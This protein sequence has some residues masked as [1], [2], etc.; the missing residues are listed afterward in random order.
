[1]LVGIVVIANGSDDRVQGLGLH[2]QHFQLMLRIVAF[3]RSQESST[4]LTPLRLRKLLSDRQT[5]SLREGNIRTAASSK[6]SKSV[7]ET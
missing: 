7:F 3:M 6:T 1:M 4:A 5:N 2:V